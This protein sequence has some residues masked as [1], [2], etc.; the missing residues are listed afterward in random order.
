MRFPPVE[1]D[2]GQRCHHHHLGCLGC[3]ALGL[4]IAAGR[5]ALAQLY[6][7]S[8]TKSILGNPYSKRRI[9][10]RVSFGNEGISLACYM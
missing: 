10:I 6:S 5:Q 9:T 3:S 7:E 4:L 1:P 2:L 8:P